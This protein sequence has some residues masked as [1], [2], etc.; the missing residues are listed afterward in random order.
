MWK[1]N[2]M[3]KL[4]EAVEVTMCFPNSIFGTL[5]VGVHPMQKTQRGESILL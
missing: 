1:N 2:M 4:H 3:K 5:G